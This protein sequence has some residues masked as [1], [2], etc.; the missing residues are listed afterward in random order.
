MHDEKKKEK[1]VLTAEEKAAAA[2]EHERIGVLY[3]A[4]L[5]TSTAHDYSVKTF[6]DTEKLLLAVPEAYTA[7]NCRRRA[8]EAIW[9]A[10]DAVVNGNEAEAALPAATSAVA[11]VMT[12]QE[13]LR[14]ELKLNSAVLL[15]NYKNYNAFVHRHWIFDQLEA[16]AK[17]EL[18]QSAQ[19][20]N[21]SAGTNTSPADPSTAAPIFALLLQLLQ[22]ERAQC[23]QLLQ[24]DERNFH[25]WNYRR[26]VLTQ[27]SRVN[28]LASTYLP[29]LSSAPKSRTAGT[30]ASFFNAEEA[31]ELAY[32]TQKIKNNFSNYSAWHDRSLALKSAV[33]RWQEQPP[34]PEHTACQAA[35]LTQLREDVSFLEQA[36]YCDPN[37]QSAWFYAPFVL[38]L[39]LHTQPSSAEAAVLADALMNSVIEL[40]AEVER[41]GR[42]DECYMPYYFLLDQLI[43]R[44][45]TIGEEGQAAVKRYTEVL[46][47][48]V[49]LSTGAAFDA[50]VGT[51]SADETETTAQQQE[52]RQHQCFSFLYDRLCKADAL[53]RGLYDDMLKRSVQTMT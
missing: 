23:E 27:E 42:K 47:T 15:L 43:S 6:D 34:S 52:R 18:E 48:K 25:A 29:S 32:T 9:K 50:I 33:T 10:A 30:T 16:L 51:A 28:A 2:A 7:Y 53:R 17:A 4:V 19:N 21:G 36:M 31:V 22:K 1:E 13:W 8:L 37:D 39:L 5:H 20:R 12:R 35:M 24:M 46:Y 41:A 11:P 26:W 44:R 49:F 40:V 45:A 38:Q 14:K 3:K